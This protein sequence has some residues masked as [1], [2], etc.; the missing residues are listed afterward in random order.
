MKGQAG[1]ILRVDLTKGTIDA[2]PLGSYAEW[3]GGHGL[4]AA[5]F[6]D[7]V[8]DKTV[9]CFDP[10]NTLVIAPGLF[11]GT[12]VPGA[13]RAELVGIQAQSYPV[14]WFG[15][16]NCGGRLASMLKFARWDAIVLE[17]AS[18]TPVWISIVD[19]DV[20]LHD[21]TGL[22]GLQTADVQKAIIGRAQTTPPMSVPP[23]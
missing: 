20:R 10:R 4:G 9:G 22:W 21:A 19:D 8:A 7:L 15:R 23:C 5:L 16:S 2:F 14:E 18:A 3:W 1:R 12:L 13:G 17:G 6:F 11:S